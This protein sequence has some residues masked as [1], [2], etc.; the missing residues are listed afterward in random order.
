MTVKTVDPKNVILTVGGYIISGYAD[1]TFVSVERNED[2]YTESVGADGEVVRVRS[3]NR[4]AQLVVTLQQTSE[5]NSVLST[6][7][8]LD[9]R[10]N[11]GVVPV[12]LKEIDG[13][14]VIA[15]GKAW[16]KKFANVEYGKEVTNR[17]WTLVLSE[18]EMFVGGNLVSNLLG[19]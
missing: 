19:L 16:I 5:S 8:Q 13:D 11:A 10:A 9:E 6:I 12:L 3:H 17:E 4:L 7:A 15:S 2:A 1:G 14:T 18:G